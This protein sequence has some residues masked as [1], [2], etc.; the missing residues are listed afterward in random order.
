MKLALAAIFVFTGQ[1]ARAEP[2]FDL[3]KCA[4]IPKIAE[5]LVEVE[6]SGKRWQGGDSVCLDQSKFDRVNAKKIEAGDSALLDPEL[7]IKKGKEVKIDP[8]IFNPITEV[9]TIHYYASGKRKNGEI[10]NIKNSILFSIYSKGA[11]KTE[12]CAML[13]EKPEHFVMREECHHE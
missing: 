10:A 3:A 1:I 2:T 9:Y 5:E 11:I 6:L 4:D 13:L 7:I 12:G 8:P